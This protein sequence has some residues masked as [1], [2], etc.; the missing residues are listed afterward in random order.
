MIRN[1]LLILIAFLGFVGEFPN[2]VNIDKSKGLQLKFRFINH[3]AYTKM[4]G[5]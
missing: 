4:L 3:T 2:I 1:I 5:V